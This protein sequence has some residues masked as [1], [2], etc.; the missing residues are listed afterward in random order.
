MGFPTHS[1]AT[2]TA[3]FV[4]S[5]AL[6]ASVPAAAADAATEQT[7]VLNWR[8]QR[9]AELTSDTGWLTLA[10]LFWL[11]GAATPSAAVRGMTSS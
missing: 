11:K 4:F 5:V 7:N 10:G 9:R 6:S 8:A 3:A 2:V 1:H